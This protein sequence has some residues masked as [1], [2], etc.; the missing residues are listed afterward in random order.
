MEN[1]VYWI[2]GG[3][4]K[5]GELDNFKAL[6]DEMVAATKE[7]EPGTLSYEW[8]ISEDGSL[9]HIY[10]RYADS[11]ATM[12]HLGNFGANYAE[13]FMSL[14]TVTTFIVYGH[15]DDQVREALSGLGAQFMTPIGGFV[16]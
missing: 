16:R 10:E 7:N 3:E 11:G 5:E 8:H 12:V 9:Y 1:Q 4:I 14:A 13:R 15:P 2:L 6:K